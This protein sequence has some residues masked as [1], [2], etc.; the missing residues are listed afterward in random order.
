MVKLLKQLT[1]YVDK[2][3]NEKTA[4]NFFVECGGERIPIE[5][6]YFNGPDGEPDR[7]YRARKMVLSSHAEELPSK[8]ATKD[9]EVKPASQ[10]ASLTPISDDLP[11]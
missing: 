1:N 7:N 9:D 8:K 6:R 4:T 5:V 10:T 3:G 11:F 2:E